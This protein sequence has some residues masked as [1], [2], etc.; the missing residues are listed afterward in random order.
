MKEK[1]IQI[2]AQINLILLAAQGLV[3]I[4]LWRFLPPEIPLFYSRPWGKDQ[5]ASYPGI[6]ILPI[7][8]LI[9]F[10]ANLV[11]AKS[12]A[13]EES[14]IKEALAITSLIFTILIFIS[15]VQIIRL[16]IQ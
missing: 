13:K 14:L 16:V 11:V 10:F 2:I 15:L 6:L 3:I 1:F 8:C 7:I 12:A 9:V 5:L 4:S